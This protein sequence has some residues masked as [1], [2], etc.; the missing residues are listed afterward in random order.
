MIASRRTLQFLALTLTLTL[1]CE[2]TIAGPQPNP[3]D[4]ATAV[5]EEPS[6]GWPS[7]FQ[8]TTEISGLRRLTTEQ[9][10]NALRSLLGIDVTGV[11][12]IEPVSPIRG[13]ATI[14][15]STA[16]VSSAGAGKFEDASRAA[17]A[18]AFAN[19]SLRSSLVPCT[20]SG[21]ADTA[22]F[23]RFVQGFGLRAFR[24]PLDADELDRYTT[25]AVTTATAANDPWAGVEAT[26]SAF[27]QSPFFLYLVETGEPDPADATRWRLTSYEVAAR[28]SFFLLNDTPDATL[29]A[30]A[31]ADQLLT[32]DGV[33][34]QAERLL[35]SNS[36][37]TAMRS[38]FTSL[39]ALEGLD[40][41]ARSPALFPAY[42]PT[43]GPALKEEALRGLEDLVFTR[44]ADWR[45]AFDANETFVN[46]ELSGFYGVSWPSGATGW[47]KSAVTKRTGLLGRA[48]VLAVHD[49]VNGTSPTK[50][51]L[52][53]LT[54][55]LC[56]D[57][58]LAPPANL[59]VPNPPSGLMTARARL[60]IHDQD[61]TCA[62]CH[63]PMDS[64]G[65]SLERFDAVG[66][67]RETDRGMA[68]DT[69]GVLE[70]RTY[71]G[72]EELSTM[73]AQHPALGP[74]L[75]QSL[76]GNGV[77]R[78]ATEFDRQTFGALV[79][80]F[81]TNGGRLRAT[82]LDVTTSDGFRTVPAPN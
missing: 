5:P 2:G 59:V 20:P 24:R 31:E 75:L 30:A 41:L 70:G 68:L 16:I 1:G 11:P 19:V 33:R 34:V 46:E 80:A 21:V 51:G 78:L 25:L 6:N 15:A 77:G 9:Y 71:D 76:Y 57:L 63:K 42:T 39:L 37:R 61:A 48:G 4:P 13:F 29:L 38:T 3:L 67:W 44:D 72:E 64:V 65:L 8:D 69:T 12:T 82:L 27:L 50:R 47:V 79:A 55:L 23:Q 17:A 45:T 74:C 40:T 28:L 7:R 53:V 32:P 36:A 14:G 49:G 73:L 52:F 18:A 35:A 10:F 81:Q 43:L 22:C 54:R 60:S 62:G 66:A 56:K 58:A 26:A